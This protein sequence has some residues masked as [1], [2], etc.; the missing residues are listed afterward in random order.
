MSPF[1]SPAS[2]DAII[3]LRQ[4]SEAWKA[5][6]FWGAVFGL[7]LLLGGIFGPE[8]APLWKRLGAMLLGALWTAFMVRT[9][10]R[11]RGTKVVYDGSTILVSDPFGARR[12]PVSQVHRVVRED[13]RQQFQ[14]LEEI[15][16]S[17]R[18]KFERMSTLPPMV[19]FI[20]QDAQG[21]ELLRLDQNMQPEVALHQLLE[22]LEAST[23]SPIVKE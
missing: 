6:L 12:I 22:R 3:T 9:A 10:L 4:P 23:G 15:G 18:Q 17:R 21:T 1:A 2:P 16:L 5:N 7:P 11:S 14:E 8:D 20:L 19:Y 13:L